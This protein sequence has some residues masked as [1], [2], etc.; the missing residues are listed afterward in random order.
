MNGDRKS[1]AVINP[2]N[3]E[4]IGEVP[5]HTAADADRAVSRRA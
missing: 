4:V 5:R 3:E 2:A 1:I